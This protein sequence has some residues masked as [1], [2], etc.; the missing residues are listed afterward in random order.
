MFMAKKEVLKK[1]PFC[2]G[3][4]SLHANIYGYTVAC[5]DYECA[6]KTLNKISKEGAITAWNRRVKRGKRK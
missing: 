1:C 4:A 2:G 5:D 3:K 6:V